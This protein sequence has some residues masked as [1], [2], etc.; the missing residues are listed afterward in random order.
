MISLYNMLSIQERQ[1]I[2]NFIIDEFEIAVDVYL[3]IKKIIESIS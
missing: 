1:G 2:S 3:Q